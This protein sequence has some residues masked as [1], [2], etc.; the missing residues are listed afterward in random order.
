MK[1]HNSIKTCGSCRSGG[2][3]ACNSISPESRK[4]LEVP[5]K[6]TTSDLSTIGARAMRVHLCRSGDDGTHR[7]NEER[8]GMINHT[9]LVECWPNGRS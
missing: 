4:L 1:T 8:Y 3:I 6:W 5:S 9:T 2:I 7:E